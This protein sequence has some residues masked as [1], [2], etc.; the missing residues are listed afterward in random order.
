MLVDTGKVDPPFHSVRE[1]VERPDH[2]IPVEP[3]VERKVVTR[4]CRNTD[5]RNVVSHCD[6][7]DERL[8]AVTARHADHVRPLAQSLFCQFQEVVT[9]LEH[10]R[11]DSA[12]ACLTRQVE[13]LGFS[14]AGLGVDQ[15]DR[16]PSPH[17]SRR[18]TRGVGSL[19]NLPA[20]ECCATCGAEHGDRDHQRNQ[21]VDH[22][23][24][25]EPDHAARQRQDRDRNAEKSREPAP[26]R[27]KP[28][29]RAGQAE[30]RQHEQERDHV[31]GQEDYERREHAHCRG[32]A[33]HAQIRAF[34]G[35]FIARLDGSSASTP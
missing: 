2:V 23:L 27:R 4:P 21:L 12:L 35:P 30:R 33:I 24:L 6:R 19:G 22:A 3:K 20:A 9:T 26:C 7:C 13:A 28:K 15:Q 29:A 18:G 31:V 25:D 32:S 16:R 34:P 14:A 8:R 17:W 5:M 11:L 10:H 1:S